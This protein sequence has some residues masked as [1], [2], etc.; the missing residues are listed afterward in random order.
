MRCSSLLPGRFTYRAGALV[1]SSL[2]LY[3]AMEYADQ[4]DLFHM[5][6]QLAEP[7]VKAIMRQLLDALRY[8]HAHGVWHRDI[9][10]ANILMTFKH[11]ARHARA[12]GGGFE[13]G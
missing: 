7:E 4:G 2:D 12:R 6:G 10:S 8:L 3:L 5:R 9:K 13:R 1:S 11:G